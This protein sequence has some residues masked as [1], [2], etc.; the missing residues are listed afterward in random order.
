MIWILELE[1]LH[2]KQKCSI[3]MAPLIKLQI[4]TWKIQAMHICIMICWMD[5]FDHN[6]L[7]SE[8]ASY[9]NAWVTFAKRHVCEGGNIL[10]LN[11]SPKWVLRKGI[12]M[13][14]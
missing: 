7:E 11:Q 14:L 8:I 10:I 1:M 6:H 12:C 5:N 2:L 4:Q 13:L 3:S 9:R